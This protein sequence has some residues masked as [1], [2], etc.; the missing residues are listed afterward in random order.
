MQDYGDFDV[1]SSWHL[2]EQGDG[3]VSTANEGPGEK[4]WVERSAEGIRNFYKIVYLGESE[5]TEVLGCA[6]GAERSDEDST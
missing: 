3:T 6:T 5:G 2:W 4:S 1:V